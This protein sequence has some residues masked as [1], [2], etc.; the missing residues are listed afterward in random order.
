MWMSIYR[1]VEAILGVCANSRGGG[2]ATSNTFPPVPNTAAVLTEA[3]E[4]KVGAEKAQGRRDWSY[5][6]LAIYIQGHTATTSSSEHSQKVGTKK[7]LNERKE[8]TTDPSPGCKVPLLPIVVGVVGKCR[9]T[10]VGVNATG[11]QHR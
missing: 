2:R 4:E 3:G 6:L 1:R 11:Q 10:A 8:Q 5:E 9:E 7:S